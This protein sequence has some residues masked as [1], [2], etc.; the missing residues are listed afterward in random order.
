MKMFL[1]DFSSK[2]GREDIFKPKIEN[3]SYTVIV[4]MIELKLSNLLHPKIPESNVHV[5]TSQHSN[6]LGRL[7]MGNSK[8]RWIIF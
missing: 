6:K 4:I 1:R 8:I 2:V 3:E 5:L 7:Q